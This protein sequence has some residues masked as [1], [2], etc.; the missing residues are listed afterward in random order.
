MANRIEPNARLRFL[1]P[2]YGGYYSETPH[3]D[4]DPLS[5]FRY[6]VTAGGSW[7]K[8]NTKGDNV[9]RAAEGAAA[10]IPAQRGLS[11]LSWFYFGGH[12]DSYTVAG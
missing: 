11:D 7:S 8:V 5:L 1:T 6:D 3:V 4:P 2:S 10:V 9:V 12:E